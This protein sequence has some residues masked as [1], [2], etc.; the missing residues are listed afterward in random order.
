MRLFFTVYKRSFLIG[1]C[2]YATTFRLIEFLNNVTKA[3]ILAYE[4]I[5]EAF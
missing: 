1:L 5:V 3:L 4:K 2:C